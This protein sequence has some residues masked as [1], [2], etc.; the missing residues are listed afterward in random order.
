MNICFVI[1]QGVV[2]TGFMY[3]ENIGCTSVSASTANLPQFL[4]TISCLGLLYL[5]CLLLGKFFLLIFQELIWSVF[6]TEV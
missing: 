3:F 5:L 2:H 1:N 6:I 4:N